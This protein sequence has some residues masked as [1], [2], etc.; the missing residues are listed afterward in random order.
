MG[1]DGIEAVKFSIT[2]R[3]RSVLWM[4]ESDR[5]SLPASQK[6]DARAML[7]LTGGWEFHLFKSGVMHDRTDG[8]QLVV[9]W[10]HYEFF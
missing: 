10:C 5:D 2:R 7:F 8:L 4:V 3:R 1:S 9:D 6:L